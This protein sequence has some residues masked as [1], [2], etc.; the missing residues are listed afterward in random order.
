[1]KIQTA[2]LTV[3]PGQIRENLR[4][5]LEEIALAK[6]NSSDILI[7]PELCLTGYFIG[8]LWEQSAFLYECMRANETI[9]RA[10]RGISIIFGGLF[11]DFDKTGDDGRPRKYNAAFCAA[12]GRLL[13]PENS[14]HPF[15]PKTL[16]PAYR[17]FD[18]RRYFTG[19]A[20]LAKEDGRPLSDILSPFVIPAKDEKLRAGIL[21]CEDSWDENYQTHPANLLSQKSPDLLVNLS[22]SPMTL[23]KADKR[24][25]MLGQIARRLHLPLLYVNQRGIQNNGKNI[26]TFD[27]M[28]AAYDKDGK[29]TFEAAPFET[30]RATFHFHPETKTLR[31]DRPTPKIAGDLLL[32]TLRYGLAKFLET[33]HPHRVVIGISGGIDSAVNAALFAS[34]LPADRLLLVNTPTRHNSETTKQLAAKLAQ[35]LAAPYLVIPIDKAADETCRMLTTLAISRGNQKE[36]LPASQ[37]TREN[38]CARLRSSGILS[39]LSSATSGIF[40]CNANK[41]EL[42]AAYTTLYGDMA[43]AI[44]ATGDLWK[45]QIYALGRALN[46]HF[47]REV[48]PEGT[49]TVPPSAELSDAQNV[50]RGGRDPLIYDYHDYLFRAFIEPWNRAT[51]EDILAWYIEGNLE[52][53]IGTPLCARDIFQTDAAFIEDLEHWWNLFAGFAVAKRI[54]APPILSVSRRSFGYDLRESQLVPYYTDRYLEMKRT[55]IP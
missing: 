28:T 20:S 11:V 33:I 54:Q 9:C 8:D 34:V 16:L 17:A 2:Q 19:A 7:L 10:A 24:H 52:E 27:G 23:G 46:D 12:G 35:N 43:G 5:A 48:I 3:L 29:L 39:A 14:P 38:I 4:R 31:G 1:M 44:A 45:H 42:C 50:D 37:T 53:K 36:T 13:Y 49:F 21:L 18:D 51:P 41:T 26:Y 15:L 6:K 47:G 32:P 55:L 30:P 40:T 25:R 22:A